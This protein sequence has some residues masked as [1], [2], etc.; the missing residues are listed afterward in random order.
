MTTRA[1]ELFEK[2]VQVAD[3]TETTLE[4]ELHNVVFSN[5]S[6][7]FT[8]A[9]LQGPGN[10]LAT[11]VGNL[12]GVQ[13]GEFIKV[14]GTWSNNPRYGRQF[15]ITSYTV[16]SPKTLVGLQRYLASGI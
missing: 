2:T 4:G 13:P 10:K 7:S 15:Q 12:V 6:G 3:G 11:V 1:P 14:S 5:E 8:V 9:R 16:H